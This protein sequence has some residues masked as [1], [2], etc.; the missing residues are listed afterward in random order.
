MRGIAEQR[1]AAVRPARQ[2]IAVDHRIFVAS[3]WRA[4]NERRH[5]EPVE[6]PVL[7][8]GQELVEP[9]GPVPVLAPPRVIGLE[10]QFRDPVDEGAAARLRRSR[11]RVADEFLD[12]VAGHDHGAAVEEGRAPR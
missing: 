9:A 8:R 12:L 11:N 4:A 7:E 10:L 1:D 3:R 5:V 2:R 6:A